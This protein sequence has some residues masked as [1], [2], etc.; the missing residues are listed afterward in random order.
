MCLSVIIPVKNRKKE[1]FNAVNSALSVSIVSEV[2][3]V[4]DS[5]IIPVS[6]QDVPSHE[7]KKI[8]IVKNTNSKG[9][10]GARIMGASISCNDIIV[11]LDSD[12]EL[13][14]GGIIS[15]CAEIESDDRLG[16]VYGNTIHDGEVSKWIP[17]AGHAFSVVL[18]NLCLCP[19]SGLVVRR[20]LVPWDDLMLELPAW[21]DDDFCLTVSKVAHIKYVDTCVA[22]AKKS[23]DSISR[24]GFNLL[25]GLSMLI[26][27]WKMDIVLNF[28]LQRL[29]LW[30]IRQL[31]IL[32]QIVYEDFVNTKKFKSK[33]EMF[34][35]KFIVMVM[36]ILIKFCKMIL[37][38]FF[39]RIYV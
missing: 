2:I 14:E 4:D 32:L 30:R 16:L 10:Q 8:V 36:Y 11:F 28:G 39:D 23:T 26:E 9:A 29:F 19:F 34:F 12:D 38:L 27:K 15:L 25:L 6:Y 17:L 13:Q 31:L 22:I 20:A 1:L 35:C 21:Q 18:K 24:N 7:T 3:I 37:R 33:T 5:S